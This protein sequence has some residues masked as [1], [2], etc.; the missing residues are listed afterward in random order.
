MTSTQIANLALDLLGEPPLTDLETDTSTTAETVRLHYN[1]TLEVLLEQHHWA[2]GT[3]PANLLPLDEARAAT[4]TLNPTGTNNDILI[5]AAA[6]GPDGNLLTA[7]IATSTGHALTV[8]KTANHI[9]IT[10][11]AKHRI[12]ITGTLSPDV[13]ETHLFGTLQN[14]RPAYYYPEFTL[15]FTSII[16]WTGTKWLII[17]NPPSPG[18]SWESTEDRAT[19]DLVTSWTATGSATGT[20]TLVA[21]PPTAAQAIAAA[22]AALE[23]TFANAP[24]SDG[25]GTL[26]AVPSTPFQG[27]RTTLLPDWGTAYDLPADCLRVLKLTGPDRG[28]PITDFRIIG[29]K[30]LL[31]PLAAL[32]DRLH[33][34]YITSD[35]SDWSATFREAFRYLLASRIATRI[36][37]SPNLAAQLLSDH[38]ET[39]A[40]ATLKD[41]QETSSNENNPMREMILRSPLARARRRYSGSPDYTP[42]PPNA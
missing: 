20:P 25:T 33:I 18:T 16:Y 30:L 26:A 38:R 19:P 14:D 12:T 15:S 41:S 8:A 7:E 31:S 24:G 1:H 42:E 21:S 13:T 39:L 22:N 27:G 36:T 9:L 6:T 32:T 10:A 37:G 29:R 40:R 3:A 4:A 11:G 17:T 2:F 23:E 5:T 35:A 28:A 34:E